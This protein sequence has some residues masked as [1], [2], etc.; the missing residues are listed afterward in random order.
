MGCSY[1][2]ILMVSKS[3]IKEKK[4]P[5][6]FSTWFI[7]EHLTGI[8]I[9]ISLNEVRRGCVCPSYSGSKCRPVT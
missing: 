2:N 9:I 7:S 3:E 1:A 4:D 5:F 6:P 8:H